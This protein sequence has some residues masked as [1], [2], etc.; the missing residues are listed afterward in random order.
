MSQEPDFDFR[1]AD[2][3]ILVKY[4][5]RCEG[6]SPEAKARDIALEQT[7]ELP[8]EAVSSEIEALVVGR[9]EN[10]EPAEGSIWNAAISFPVAAVGTGASQ[11]FGLLFGNISLK[12]G[13]FVTDVELPDRLL[14]LFPGPRFGI[15]GL[16]RLASAES[17]RPL[18][19]TALKPMGLSAESLAELCYGFALA[20]CDIIKDDHGL[21]N[22]PTA[23][24]EE[25]V[26]RCAEAVRSANEETG[27]HSL[28]F[29]NVV[30]S[31][32][33]LAEDLELV[34]AAGCEGILVSPLVVGL[35]TVRWIAAN[36]G[37]AILSHPSIA[38]AFFRSDHGVSP[39][40][41]LGQLFRVVGSDGVIYPNVGGRFSLSEKDCSAINERLRC[42][43]GSVLPSFPVPAGGIDTEQVPHWIE[44]YGTDTMFLIG[45][46]LYT[47][48]DLVEA[49]RNLV[50]ALRSHL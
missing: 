13:V 17:D 4:Q 9:I 1:P 43:M 30:S 14:R 37:L 42:Q 32:P 26:F 18:L 40:L 2:Q 35:D 48:P 22:Q 11:L 39:A 41:L 5:L 10:L 20:G 36:A 23:R 6:E 21:V 49:T 16:R 15:N 38:G 34:R 19:C 25:R 47:K 7:V 46:S 3:R 28:Y 12:T 8:S 45:G 24:F 27:G 44:R 31:G 50:G 33:A 29:P